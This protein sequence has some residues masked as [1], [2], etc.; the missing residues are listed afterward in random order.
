MS[1][2]LIPKKKKSGAHFTVM[3]AVIPSERTGDA[4]SV[5]ERLPV[6]GW[7]D[8]VDP[9]SRRVL[10]PAIAAVML[11]LVHLWPRGAGGHAAFASTRTSHPNLQPPGPTVRS[12]TRQ[13]YSDAVKCEIYFQMRSLPKLTGHLSR[14]KSPM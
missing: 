7:V 8:K 12:A 13:V 10:A 11:L 4:G 9:V 5:V 14:T 2:F 3:F 1:V 6:I